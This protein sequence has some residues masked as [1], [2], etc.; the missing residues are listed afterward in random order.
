MH[1]LT[2]S[3]VARRLGKSVATVRRLERSVLQPKRGRA[4]TWLFDPDAV[5]RLARS[6]KL[7][8]GR[9]RSKW[10]EQRL[11]TK[12]R[13]HR[14]QRSC[15]RSAPN[16]T[17]DRGHGPE[18]RAVLAFEE[19]FEDIQDAIG[20]LVDERVLTRAG[21]ALLLELADDVQQLTAALSTGDGQTESQD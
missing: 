21:A 6:P 19:A 16:D 14:S 17:R 4:G 15:A 3:Q 2:R 7:A 18:R 5:E 13:G 12:A 10:F 9:G 1:W 20:M 11:A 8:A